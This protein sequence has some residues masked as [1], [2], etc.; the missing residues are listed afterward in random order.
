MDHEL[1]AEKIKHSVK[2][3]RVNVSGFNWYANSFCV[4]A[5]ENMV[6]KKNFM[7]MDALKLLAKICGR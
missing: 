1:C 3:N 5:G 4:H 6:V 7:G 2:K